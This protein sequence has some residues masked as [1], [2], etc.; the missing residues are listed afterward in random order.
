MDYAAHTES[1]ERLRLLVNE[2]LER[3]N[4][5]DVTPKEAGLVIMGLTHRLM[6]VLENSPEERRLFILDFI[7]MVNQYLAGEFRQ[8]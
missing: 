1:S 5:A 7:N 3:F 6:T 2:V 4:Q 8:D